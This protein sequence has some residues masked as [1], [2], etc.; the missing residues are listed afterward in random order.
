MPTSTTSSSNLT[1]ESLSGPNA[2][3][4]EVLIPAGYVTTVYDP[5]FKLSPDKTPIRVGAVAHAD[6]HSGARPAIL[7]GVPGRARQGGRPPE[8]RLRL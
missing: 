6:H 8:D 7:A 3:L 4:T 2:G 1:P 5:V